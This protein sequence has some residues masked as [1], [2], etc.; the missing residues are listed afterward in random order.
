ML[1]AMANVGV[2]VA[3]AIFALTWLVLPG[4]GVIDLSVTWNAD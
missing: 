3:A 1:L 4:F 2:R